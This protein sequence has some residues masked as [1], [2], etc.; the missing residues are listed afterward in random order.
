[1][2]ICSRQSLRGFLYLCVLLLTFNYAGAQSKAGKVSVKEALTQVTKIYGT[3][4]MYEGALVNGKTTTV[5]VKAQSS[6]PVEEV[7]KGILYPNDLLFLYVDKNHYTIVAKQS[8]QGIEAQRAAAAQ[9]ALQQ[10]PANKVFGTVV[11]DS[12]NPVPG[13]I[14]MAAG[15]KFYTGTNSDGKF[16]FTLPDS[17][18]TVTVSFPGMDRQVVPVVIGQPL[19]V[20][21]VT[22]VLNEVVVTGY[23]TISRERATGS[24]ATVKA[25]DLDKRRISSLNQVLEGNLP[26]VMVYKDKIQVRGQSTFDTR[27][28]NPLYV[29]DGFPVENSTIDANG[30]VV[31]QTPNINP[32]DIESITVLKDA[33]AASIYGARAANGVIVITT[34]K[35]KK[36][37][38]S[39]NFSADYAVTPKWDLSYRKRASSA[40]MVDLTTYYFDNNPLFVTNPIGTAASIRESASYNNPAMELLLQVAEGKITRAEADA[41]L[42]V[43]KGTNQ[44]NQQILDR[45]IRPK[46]NQQYN[47][48]IGKASESNVFNLSATFRNDQAYSINDNNKFLGVNM[49]N[50]T[51]ISKWLTA[52]VGVY[53]NY[54]DGQ[55]PDNSTG[56][57]TSGSGWFDY[58]MPYESALD[59]YGNLTTLRL[60][61]SKA[62]QDIIKNNGLFNLGINPADEMNYNLVKS[63]GW[64]V[65]TNLRLNAKITKWLNYDVMFQYERNTDK[66]EQF[67]DQNSRYMRGF[68]NSFSYKDAGNNLK[69]KV[70]VGN[71]LRNTLAT[72]RAYTFRQQLNF[73]HTFNRKHELVGLLGSEVRESKINRDY[74]ALF[75]YDWQTM[76]SM[77]VNVDDVKNGFLGLNGV[78]GQLSASDL[79]KVREVINRFVSLYGNVAYTYNE[80]YMLSGSARMD[81]SNLFGTNPKYQYRPLWSAGAGWIMSK[82]DFMSGISWLDMLKLRASYGVNGNVSK[83]ASPYMVAN[84]GASNQTGNLV[85]SIGSPPNPNLR[86]EKTAT[87][88]VGFDFATLSNRLSGTMDFYVR[89]STD[90][91]ANLTL[92]PALGFSTSKVNN[93]G[94]RNSG[95]EVSVRGNVLR[96]RSFNWDVTVNGSYNK[97]KVTKV[98]YDPKLISELIPNAANYYL[99]GDPFYSIYSYRYAG[100]NEKGNGMIYGLDGKPTDALV[101]NPD[102]L[103]YSGTY[104]PRY[105]GAVINNLSYKQF[106]FSFMLVFNAGHIMRYEV[107]TMNGGYPSGVYMEGIMNAWKKPGDELTTDIPK[108]SFDFD[109]TVVSQSRSYYMYSEKS[110]ANASFIKARNLSLSYNLPQDWLKRLKVANARIRFQ[111]DN[112]F[113]IGFN[114]QGIDPEAA[115]ISNG[116]I[117][118]GLPIMPTYNFGINLSI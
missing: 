112:L 1:M 114:G 28:A 4:F 54:S 67:M 105:T 10:V 36:G 34:K 97:N 83:E 82:E 102:V 100:V 37:K 6:R 78:R 40:E 61:E 26:G 98:D 107:P 21:L 19:A 80:K 73:N 20:K 57:I 52:D 7:L 68:L 29:I 72:T 14:V 9:Q 99:Q 35:A 92:D 58:L 39:I 62:T 56:Q 94:M 76:S 91:L 11:D 32:E 48:S 70:P 109:K 17:V 3:T 59:E 25:A 46:Q 110:I 8:K 111:A 96:N 118:R 75:G 22:K 86:W 115:S 101:T 93:G 108:L 85:G 43:L 77:P 55:S 13:A 106:Q 44:Y 113:Y 103:I 31:D 63:K 89:N 79:G 81:L 2:G 41:Q 69:F 65:R 66:I 74:F 104:L 5:D 23:Q 88:N 53:L 50:S 116:S 71:S 64:D 38:T 117:S 90:L 87:T 47:L 16:A 15:S 95:V 27:G 51:Q 24:F 33:A 30:W 12:N 18:K 42:E 60:K 49:R 45:L 84:Y